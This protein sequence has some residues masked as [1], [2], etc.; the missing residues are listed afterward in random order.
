MDRSDNNMFLTISSIVLAIG[1]FFY[2]SGPNGAAAVPT[3][4]ETQTIPEAPPPEPDQNL[5]QE[6][7][8]PASNKP[9]APPPPPKPVDPDAL[10]PEQI[11]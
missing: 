5:A 4:V 7:E 1:F 6:E 11:K 8:T 9:P 2:L 3:H 10:P